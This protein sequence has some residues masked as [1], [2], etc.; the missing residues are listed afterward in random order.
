MFTTSFQKILR[1]L[2]EFDVYH[3]HIGM[4]IFNSKTFVTGIIYQFNEYPLT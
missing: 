1:V 2:F 3:V 4:L